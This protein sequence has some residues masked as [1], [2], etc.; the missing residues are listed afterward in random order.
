MPAKAGAR[1][2]LQL[3]VFAARRR[4]LHRIA[5]TIIVLMLMKVLMKLVPVDKFT[6]AADLYHMTTIK[7]RGGKPIRW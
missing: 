2:A 5:A 7:S 3:D 4:P 1:G 6:V